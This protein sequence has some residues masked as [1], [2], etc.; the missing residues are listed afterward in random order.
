MFFL[1]FISF[2]V[3]IVAFFSRVVSFFVA[4]ATDINKAKFHEIIPESVKET[5]LKRINVPLIEFSQHKVLTMKRALLGGR[6]LVKAITQQE[7]KDALK[8]EGVEVNKVIVY[9]IIRITGVHHIIVDGVKILLKIEG[10]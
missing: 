4:Y 1:T 6:E 5:H 9:K 3:F 10:I 7:I 2:D 8:K